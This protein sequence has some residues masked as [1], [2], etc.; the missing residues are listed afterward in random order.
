MLSR[1]P[2]IIIIIKR[3]CSAQAYQSMQFRRRSLSNKACALYTWYTVLHALTVRSLSILPALPF[4]SVSSKSPT[5]R[6]SNH[7]NSRM[8][9]PI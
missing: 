6:T 1:L 8:A 3:I 9:G 4:S 7:Y 2:F 5:W